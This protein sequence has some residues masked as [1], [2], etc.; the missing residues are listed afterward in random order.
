MQL[1]KQG[2]LVKN[3]SGSQLSY[4]PVS[5]TYITRN[6]LEC[7]ELFFGIEKIF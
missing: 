4:T 2:G 3:A 7:Q 6:T 5:K 1:L